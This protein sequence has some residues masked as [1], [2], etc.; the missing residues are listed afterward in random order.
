MER[1]IDPG[2]GG[3]GAEQQGNR[4]DRDVAV[5]DLEVQV[6]ARGVTGGADVADARAARDAL[7]EPGVTRDRCAYQ[8]V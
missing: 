1:L 3:R 8:L 5:T 2:G 6:R 7:A 4:V